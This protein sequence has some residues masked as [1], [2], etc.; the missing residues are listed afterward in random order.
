MTSKRL[1]IVMEIKNE[2]SADLILKELGERI[3]N[4]R[5]YANV[6]QSELASISGVSVSTI[7]R[8]EN[9]E[10]TKL[11]NV[12]K[13]LKGLDLAENLNIV[14]PKQKTSYKLL[15]ELENNP[16]YKGGQLKQRAGRKPTPVKPQTPWVW[17]EDKPNKNKTK[18]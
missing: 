18:R 6:K 14:V 13:V 17:G 12:I 16:A 3:K 8:I 2:Y 1:E 5:V 9:G 10:D 7:V 15:Y 4:H 11:S